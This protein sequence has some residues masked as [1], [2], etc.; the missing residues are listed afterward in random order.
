MEKE[1][2]LFEY[3]SEKMDI[4]T[5]THKPIIVDVTKLKSAST[6]FL[7][8]LIDAKE[9]IV[10]VNLHGQPEQ[11]FNIC[12]LNGVVKTFKNIDEAKSFL[13]K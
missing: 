11:I 7:H 10:V 6:T 9:R 1:Y 13:N 4:P 5:N 2:M 12:G 3:E 8:K